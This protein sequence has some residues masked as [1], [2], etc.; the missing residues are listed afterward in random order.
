MNRDL[1]QTRAQVKITVQYKTDGFIDLVFEFG[2]KK[3]LGCNYKLF[4]WTLMIMAFF[5]FNATHVYIFVPKKNTKY[6]VTNTFTHN[7]LTNN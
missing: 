7:L 5:K 3:S 4:I 1:K 6:R 2:V